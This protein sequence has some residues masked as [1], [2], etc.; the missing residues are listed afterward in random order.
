M[1]KIKKIITSSVVAAVIATVGT[2]T[3]LA[4]TEAANPVDGVNNQVK[5][6]YMYFDWGLG[7]SKVTNITESERYCEAFVIAYDQKTGKEVDRSFNGKNC[8]HNESVTAKVNSQYLGTNYNYYCSGGIRGG[9]TS[10]SPI[11]EDEERY[12]PI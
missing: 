9:A 5:G 1:A 4:L 3:A 12:Y 11:I 6:T 7:Y 10:S 2:T 8:D